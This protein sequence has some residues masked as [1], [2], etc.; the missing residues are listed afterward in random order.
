MDIVNLLLAGGIIFLGSFFATI[1]GFGFALVAT[2][3][4]SL[5]MPVKWAIVF[6]LTLTVVLRS[7]T[8]LRVW[9]QF[10]WR[11]VL[12]TSLGS[13][14]GTV[15]GSMLLRRISVSSLELFL[16]VLLLVVTFL[17][18]RQYTV[19]IANKTYGRL[20]AGI[21][22][23]FF[24]ACTSVGGPPLALYF[25][26]EHTEK[27]LM[28][29]NM[30]WIFGLTGFLTL[31]V[32]YFVGNIGTVGDWTYLYTMLPGTLI[33]IWAGERLVFRLNQELFRRLSLLIVFFGAF[34]MLVSG[35]QGL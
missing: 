8:M 2:P 23:G 29:A 17:M 20:G 10:D 5:I 31:I 22:S 16:G 25:L 6:M 15:P 34:M 14:I 28:R 32:N 19:K 18:S 1:S 33:G 11:T 9:G 26:N 13:F 12:I 27:D 7:L 30:I 24:G 21:L 35:W 4:L 3:L